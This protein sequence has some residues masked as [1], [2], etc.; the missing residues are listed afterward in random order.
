MH[1]RARADLG[2]RA[3]L[4]RDC[5][6]SAAYGRRAVGAGVGG[7]RNRDNHHICVSRRAMQIAS[8]CQIDCAVRTDASGYNIPI[9]QEGEVQADTDAALSR[10]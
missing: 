8:G 7:C 10:G 3:V 2:Q 9:Q 4:R 6:Q 1:L 5:I